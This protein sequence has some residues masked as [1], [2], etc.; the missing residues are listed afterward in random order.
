M[1]SGFL[2]FLE[3]NSIYIVMSIVLVVW[4]GIFIFLLNTDKRLKA[5]E[6]ELKEK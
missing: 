1:E 6:K 2:G 5:I 3:K 4:A